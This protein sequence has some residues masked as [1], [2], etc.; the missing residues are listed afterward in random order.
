MLKGFGPEFGVKP[1]GYVEAA[2]K[3]EVHLIEWEGS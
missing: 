1:F 3:R 2:V